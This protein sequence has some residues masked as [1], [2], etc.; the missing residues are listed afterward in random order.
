MDAARGEAKAAPSSSSRDSTAASSTETLALTVFS[1]TSA[2]DAEC[3]D[4]QDGATEPLLAR[5]KTALGAVLDEEKAL[6]AAQRP[7]SRWR[8]VLRLAG[9]ALV[10]G[11]LVASSAIFIRVLLQQRHAVVPSVTLPSTLDST[12]ASTLS[13]AQQY[14]SNISNSNVGVIPF[15][16]TL[17]KPVL[18]PKP[19]DHTLSTEG[20]TPRCLERYV[21]SG[22]LCVELDGRWNDAPPKLDLIWTWVNGS[23][24]EL[25]AD[26]RNKVA[27]D[28][29]WRIRLRRALQ[30]GAAS[31]VK[32]FREHDELR[33]SMRSAL[34][35]LPDV[36]IATL[37][38]VVGDTPAYSPFA[39][40]ALDA[41]SPANATR[42]AQ[43]P[44]WLGLSNIGLSEPAST[45]PSLRIPSLLVHPHSELF[46]SAQPDSD[47]T[48]AADWRT[49]VVPSFNSLAIESQLPNLPSTAQTAL[50]LNDDFFLMRTLAF[51]DL[52]S[53]LSGPVFR[54]QRD[55]LVGGVAPGTSTDDPDGEWKGLG[56]SNWLLDQR[57]GKRKRPYL[58]HVAKTI[59][60]PL[61]R[62]VQL[63]FHEELSATAEARFRGK[64]PNE[65]QPL[66]LATMY[67]IERHREALLWSFL[68]AR[69]DADHSGAYSASERGALLVDLGVDP[70]EAPQCP[71]IAVPRP[72]RDTVRALAEDHAKA[73]LP[74]PL[75]TTTEFSSHDGYALLGLE[76]KMPFV[77]P[78]REWPALPL[79]AAPSSDPICVLDIKSCFGDDFVSLDERK[80]DVSTV[81]KRVAFEQTHC[82]DC[83]M[84]LLVG[85]SGS[86]GLGAFLPEEEEAVEVAEMPVVTL[87]G[88]IKTRW[89]DV[90]YAAPLDGPGTLRQKAAALIQRYSYT[91]CSSPSSFQSIRYAGPSLS[92]R[93]DQLVCP[94]SGTAPPAFVALNDDIGAT[95][96]DALRDIDR[97]MKEWFEDTWPEKAPSEQ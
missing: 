54:M 88:S 27:A 52:A 44:H 18:R 50:Y 81:F 83:L 33:Y 61:L 55:L 85:K 87:P 63:V 16:S 31:V 58:V 80:V 30:A 21:A 93:L 65:V 9:A 32:H 3:E 34:A 96:S 46:K 25:M 8:T 36:S 57:F 72:R 35:S 24:A 84:A 47:E 22:V 5:D 12:N 69:T 89:Q 14:L 90:D 67:I 68:V 45:V 19:L 95:S 70:A 74:N 79:S 59:S 94:P 37:H 7:P 10:F 49:S 43:I 53:P 38:L 86:R 20:W 4:G 75:E 92:T 66:F 51:T 6:T 26:W 82:G 13:F 15:P 23:S 11:M 64:A 77:Y 91:L 1:A 41:A 60:M 73:G 39:P 78:S 56:Y 62:E 48:Q 2:D 97:R 17:Y 28:A 29:G 71:L 42:F 76:T 40:P